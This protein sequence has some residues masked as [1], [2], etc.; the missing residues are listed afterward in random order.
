MRNKTL[1]SLIAM[2]VVVFAISLTSA[3]IVTITDVEVNGVK[4][5]T[6]APVVAG[7]VGDIVPVEV[8]FTAIQDVEDVRVRVFIEGFRDDVSITTPRFH[9]V[10]DSNYI[11]R[12]SVT[13]PESL[14]LDELVEEVTLTVRI[15]ARGE[16]SVEDEYV[17]S[18]QKELYEL[19]FLSVDAQ[20]S[21]V[22]GETV[23]LDVVLSNIGHA[24]LDN[25]YVKASIPELG[26]SRRIYFG[27][28]APLEEVS[29]DDV[30]NTVNRR[31]LLPIPADTAPGVYT[32]EIEG[33]NRDAGLTAT[34]RINV[35]ALEGDVFPSITSR[36]VSV[37]D[38]TTFSFV[39]VNPNNKL[40]VYTLT[41][42]Q[43]NGITVSLPEPVVVLPAG[44]SRTVEVNVK[45]TQDANKGTHIVTINAVSDTDAKSIDFTLNVDE[46]GT[47]NSGN[48]S[49]ISTG[50]AVVTLT[51]ILVIIFVVLLIVLIVLL[52][53]QPEESEEFGETSYY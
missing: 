28:L 37:G 33:F 32:I 51:V 25:N 38:S 27:D 53:R 2:L 35:V 18:L 34:K 21:V 9:I 14:D 5:T 43:T 6:T 40:V 48:G 24:R 8:E 11:K 12:F 49:G 1:L 41:P 44:S 52:T 46:T 29:L 4:A 23:V 20:D 17:L 3:Q 31:V 7:I 42:S 50:N 30:R 45:A 26:V 15:S 36:T 19:D 22:A 13:L 47:R 10:K 39:L 16:N